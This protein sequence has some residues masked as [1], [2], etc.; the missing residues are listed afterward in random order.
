[1]NAPRGKTVATGQENH[2]RFSFLLLL[3]LPALA[4]CF[5]ACGHGADDLKTRWEKWQEYAKSYAASELFP[6]LVYPQGGDWLAAHHEAGE[7]FEKYVESRPI[8]LTRERNRIVLQP[9]GPFTPQ[10]EKLLEAMRE[11]M[12]I[13]F[14]C[15]VDL[16]KPVD[17]PKEGFR[18]RETGP[19]YL[20]SSITSGILLPRL[21]DDA[22]S[23]VGITCADI[24]PGPGWNFV[25]GEAYLRERVAVQSLARYYPSFYGEKA[26]KD[27]ETV[28]LRRTLKTMTHE[29]GHTF[30]MAHCVYFECNMAGSNSLPESD[31]RPLHLC[32]VCLRKLQWNRGFDAAKRYG[33]LLG[34]YGKHG[35]APEAE[36][37][38]KRLKEVK[39]RTAGG[40]DS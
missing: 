15:K 38:E 26:P 34:F 30:S 22:A 2:T 13:Y 32:P 21:P 33:E 5:T 1:M 39:A 10:Q 27:E 8:K 20:T 12:A 35:L 14:Q 7:T 24:Y 23:Y 25:F 28:V 40:G 9:V 19:Q 36:W 37:I 31:R 17:L 16:L 3:L 11:F 6:P 4:L 29:T 18:Q